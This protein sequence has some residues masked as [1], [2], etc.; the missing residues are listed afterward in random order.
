MN[1]Q[2]RCQN[3]TGF[4]GIGQT[5]L[6]FIYSC[7]NLALSSQ[8]HVASPTPLLRS[9]LLA[10]KANAWLISCCLL[11]VLIADKRLAAK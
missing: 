8:H 4:R 9:L 5:L 1:D 2:S 6:H 7:L 11:I 3:Y 10:L